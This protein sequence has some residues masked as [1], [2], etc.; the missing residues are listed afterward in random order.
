MDRAPTADHWAAEL[1]TLLKEQVAAARE[2][3]LS[4]V[5][6]LGRAVDAVIGRADQSFGELSI[7]LG[8]RRERV[9]RLYRELSLM[10]S[11]ERADVQSELQKLRRVKRAVDAYGGATSP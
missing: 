1:C 2:G 3:D 7:A 10:L 8:F 11:A 9:E 5:E 6:R 4:R